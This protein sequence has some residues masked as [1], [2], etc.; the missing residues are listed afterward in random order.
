MPNVHDVA[1]YIL[2]RKGRMSPMTLHRL[3]Y[4][5]Q[6]WAT[7]WLGEALFDERIEAW[8]YGPVVPSL[9][10]GSGGSLLPDEHQRVIDAVLEYY[11]RF[12]AFDL[13]QITFSE[14]PWQLARK[15]VPPGEGH[16]EI[17]LNSMREFYASL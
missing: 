12:G 2:E 10:E 5:S 11:G 17:T 14:A 7:V 9:F 1:A 4:Y 3:V 8:P 6:A 13:S 15:G 16:P